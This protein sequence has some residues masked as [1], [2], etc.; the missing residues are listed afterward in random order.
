M[1]PHDGP[2]GESTDGEADRPRPRSRIQ[3]RNRARILD[4]A[5]DVFSAQGFR[6][7]TLD[8]IADGAGMSKPNVLYYFDGKEAIHVS[9][10]NALM[11][12]WL[13]PLRTLQD[14][15]APLDAL[16]DYVHA[17]LDMSFTMPRESRLFASEVLQ[18]A[19]RMSPHLES[20]LRPLLDEK[21][22]LI[23]G[24]MA[25]GRIARTDPRH[26]VFSIWAVTQHYA[27]FEAQVRV[28]DDG[29]VRKAAEAH[30]D[31]LFRRLLTP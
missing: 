17:K 11:D 26:L 23:G 14:T 28:L 19:P 27:D 22:A 21:C 9:L 10:L 20:G 31:T 13:D 3:K 18:G 24:W 8:Q 30:V 5:L 2:L 15:D 16:M 4:A 1:S 6:G 29:P 12:R 25:A 7:S